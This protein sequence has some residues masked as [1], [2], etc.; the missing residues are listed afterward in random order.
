MPRCAQG[1]RFPRRQRSDPNTIA[2]ADAIL[3]G[4]ARNR[5]LTIGQIRSIAIAFNRQQNDI[6]INARLNDPIAINVRERLAAFIVQAHQN[7]IITTDQVGGLIWQMMHWQRDPYSS[8]QIIGGLIDAGIL[9]AQGALDLLSQRGQ[10]PANAQDPGAIDIT[11]VFVLEQLF[12]AGHITFDQLLAGGQT[13]VADAWN[14]DTA[15]FR[16]TIAMQT[17][18]GDGLISLPQAIQGL[19][20]VHGT[21]TANDFEAFFAQRQPS[22]ADQVAAV[23]ELAQTNGGNALYLL[24]YFES[25]HFITP[26]GAMELVEDLF[27]DGLITFD[28]FQ[29][30]YN[31]R[32][33]YAGEL[34][35]SGQPGE[36]TQGLQE[37]QNLMWSLV[38][39]HAEQKITLAQA[40]LAMFGLAAPTEAEFGRLIQNLIGTGDVDEAAAVRELMQSD[41][42]LAN[43]L[44]S[45]FENAGS[46]SP[47]DATALRAEVQSVIAAMPPAGPGDS[48]DSDSSSDWDD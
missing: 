7:G 14:T 26:V 2:V 39:L 40:V 21:P 24:S 15:R 9:T 5:N 23:R 29:R 36:A 46:L 13:A 43:R 1:C 12:R 16:M 19:F 44:I 35:D 48:S 32:S 34:Q 18:S 6:P 28:Q 17:L 33:A 3:N 25:S 45:Y 8:A 42:A 30:D 10:M 11:R 27:R 38:G 20:S 47:E 41:P 31:N 22:V 37:S 4:L